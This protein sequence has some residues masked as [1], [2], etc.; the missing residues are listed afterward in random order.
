MLKNVAF[1]RTVWYNIEKFKMH[2]GD[3]MST[4]D[5]LSVDYTKFEKEINNFIEDLL[6]SIS[7]RNSQIGRLYLNDCLVLACLEN[8]PII[9]LSDD[10]YPVIAKRYQ[11]S[12]AGVSKAIRH[13]LITCFNDGNLKRINRIFRCEIVGNAPPTNAEF[14]TTI[15]IFV[16]RYLRTKDTD[17]SR[18]TFFNV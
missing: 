1:C 9:N 15:V 6:L 16:K 18:V 17:S 8:K 11:T 3:A 10:I 5:I 12:I 4:N 13:C 7:F 14:I 2:E